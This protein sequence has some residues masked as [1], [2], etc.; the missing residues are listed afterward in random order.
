[1]R[2]RILTAFA[3]VLSLPILILASRQVNPPVKQSEID[4]LPFIAGKLKITITK[5]KNNVAISAEWRNTGLGYVEM[6]IENLSPEFT[7]FVPHRL[8]FVD[9]DNDQAGILGVRHNDE[10]YTPQESRIAPQARIKGRFT[11]TDKLDPPVRIYYDDRLL[12]TIVD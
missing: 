9:R 3:A 8:L 11:L 5:I 12:G 1:M 2:S 6:T 7:S 10:I 4:R